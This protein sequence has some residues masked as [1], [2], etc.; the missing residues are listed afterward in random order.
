MKL[1]SSLPI[2]FGAISFSITGIK[3][4]ARNKGSLPPAPEYWTAAQSPWATCPS[5]RISKTE[6]ASPA[7]LIDLNPG[8]TGVPR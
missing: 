5:S 2:N 7:C 1:S 8:V 4:F 3:S 6:I